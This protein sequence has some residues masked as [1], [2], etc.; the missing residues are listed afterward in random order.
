MDF[1]DFIDFIDFYDLADFRDFPDKIDYY[2]IDFPDLLDITDL[3]DLVGDRI[4]LLDKTEILVVG[5]FRLIL[6]TEAFFGL[7]KPFEI[8]LKDF[9]FFSW[10]PFPVTF[11]EGSFLNLYPSAYNSSF[12]MLLSQPAS[13]SLFL[14]E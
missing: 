4:D 14:A 8:L 13:S 2:P 6:L 9:F 11:L 3:T 10:F 12:D 5:L 1:T 7:V